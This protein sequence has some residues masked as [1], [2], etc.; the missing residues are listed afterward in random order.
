MEA[1]RKAKEEKERRRQEKNRRKR[2]AYR[3]RQRW[4]QGGF[5]SGQRST[6]KK[7]EKEN[8]KGK[9]EKKSRDERK[10]NKSNSDSR[11][12][13]FSR[14]PSLEFNEAKWETS[15]EKALQSKNFPRMH[16][17]FMSRLWAEAKLSSSKK[18]AIVKAYRA[19]STS[20]HPDRKSVVGEDSNNDM[21]KV[22]FQALNAAKC[23]CLEEL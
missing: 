4:K 2:K 21:Y 13:S 10:K 9:S 18:S 16:H 11:Q 1:K 8:K 6:W 23:S 5:A 19:L 15:M 7:Q 20:Y 3:E 14:T 17:L 22:A 12:K